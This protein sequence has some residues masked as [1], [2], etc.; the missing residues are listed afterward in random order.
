MSPSFDVYQ[1]LVHS[2]LRSRSWKG[3]QGR[4]VKHRPQW[5]RSCTPQLPPASPVQ[6]EL[7][8]SLCA[9]EGS[10]GGQED[11]DVGKVVVIKRRQQRF[12]Q[13]CQGSRTDTSDFAGLQLA[14]SMPGG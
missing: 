4:R 14:H 10:V 8:H 7:Q 12:H 1:P 13:A 11:R 6:E 9:G 3:T 5:R 2:L